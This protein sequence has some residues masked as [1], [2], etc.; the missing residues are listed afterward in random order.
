MVWKWSPS[1]IPYQGSAEIGVGGV[2]PLRPPQQVPAFA[3]GRHTAAAAMNKRDRAVDFRIVVKNAGSIDLFGDEF[4][5]RCRAIHRCEN[6]DVVARA[7]F[8]VG[9][10]I[11]FKRRALLRRQDLVV[12]CSFG[13]PVVA[14]E[15]MQSHILLVHPVAGR[16][17]L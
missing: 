10:Q 16:N 14:C 15:V 3:I 9:P 2:T 5:D 8:S 11:A 6:A 12:L 7:G 17:G 1:T 13:K 4:C